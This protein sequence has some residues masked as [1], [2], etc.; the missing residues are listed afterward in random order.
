MAQMCY[1]NLYTEKRYDNPKIGKDEKKARIP[2]NCRKNTGNS[3]PFH[4]LFFYKFKILIVVHLVMSDGARVPDHQLVVVGYG[5]A[6]KINVDK[7][8]E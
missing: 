6:F 1:K 7:V 4:F 8:S 5:S 2:Y 3:K